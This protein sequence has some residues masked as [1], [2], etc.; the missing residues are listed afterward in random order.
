MVFPTQM[1]NSLSNILYLFHDLFNAH[2]WAFYECFDKNCFALR[3]NF[4]YD[5][6]IRKIITPIGGKMF[7]VKKVSVRFNAATHRTE[8][9]L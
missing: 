9:F 1:S 3:G 5:E 8:T 6:K 2:Y 7:L 4:K